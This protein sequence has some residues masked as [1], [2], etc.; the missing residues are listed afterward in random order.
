VD[1]GIIKISPVLVLLAR[2][3]TE[4][5]KVSGHA[6]TIELLPQCCCD[7]SDLQAL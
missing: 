3:F 4:R 6:A 1:E 5:G 2:P 7:Q